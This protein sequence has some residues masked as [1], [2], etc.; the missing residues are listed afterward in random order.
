[1]QQVDWHADLRS[2]LHGIESNLRSVE[3]WR[4]RPLPEAAVKVSC[5]RRLLRAFERQLNENIGPVHLL[6]RLQVQKAGGASGG[7]VWRAADV[8]DLF[9]AVKV[10][11]THADHLSGDLCPAGW[12]LQP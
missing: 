11:A 3:S 8:S 9:T 1:M 10:L 6:W 4:R 2:C 7:P 12:W 5:L